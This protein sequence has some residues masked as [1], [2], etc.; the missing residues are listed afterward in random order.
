MN[1][2]S[3]GRF[4]II[5]AMA[6]IAGFGCQHIGPRTIADD[7][8]AYNNAI[9]TS[10]EQQAL[11]NIV[12]VRY[13]DLVQFVDVGPV[14]QTH[15]LQGTTTASFGASILPWNAIMNTLTPGLTGSRQT[16]DSPNITYTP[17]AG[18]DLTKNVNRPLS[19]SDIFAYLIESG[20]R[21]DVLMPLTKPF[22]APIRTARSTFTLLLTLRAKTRRSTWSSRIRTPISNPA[23]TPHLSQLLTFVKNFTSKLRRLNLRSWPDHMPR[24]KPKSP[25]KLDP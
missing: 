15:S 23:N 4:C 24:K 18:S 11:L 1:S 3:L 8:L 12:R 7:R 25:S 14:V 17:L 22:G 10:W 5:A 2:R 21:A 20:Y 13:D 6:V 9:L 16:T 19:P